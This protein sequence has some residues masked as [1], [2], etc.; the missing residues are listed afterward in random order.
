MLM[1]SLA[2]VDLDQ[3]IEDVQHY[4]NSVELEQDVPVNNE[5]LQTEQS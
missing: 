3:S 5:V 1:T 2:H 4:A